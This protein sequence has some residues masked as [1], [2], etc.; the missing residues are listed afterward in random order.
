M[1]GI[2]LILSLLILFQRVF[3]LRI[4]DEDLSSVSMTT[5]H[6]V[7]MS[8]IRRLNLSETYK[9][10]SDPQIRKDLFPGKYFVAGYGSWTPYL[11]TFS[12]LRQVAMA[13]YIAVSFSPNGNTCETF[14]FC[15]VYP[16]APSGARFDLW[17]H[18]NK[19]NSDQVVT[20]LYFWLR[21]LPLLPS[22]MRI[23][24]GLIFPDHIDEKEIESHFFK[25]VCPIVST[26]SIDYNEELLII[27]QMIQK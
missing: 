10:L 15:T 3:S 16:L 22:K 23:S 17:C 5:S 20:Y 26:Q 6:L 7:P 9:I 4:T 14:S 8:N 1:F 19:L 21:H 18:G 13:S 11:S 2:N 24:I 27:D 25:D 12:N